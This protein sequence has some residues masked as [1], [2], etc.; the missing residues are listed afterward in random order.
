MLLLPLHRTFLD[1]FYANIEVQILGFLELALHFQD[2]AVSLQKKKKKKTGK[3]FFLC[4]IESNREF[5]VRGAHECFG[6]PVI[7]FNA[8]KWRTVTIYRITGLPG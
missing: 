5:H 4:S 6:N 7:F 1:P 3:L 8:F 2:Q